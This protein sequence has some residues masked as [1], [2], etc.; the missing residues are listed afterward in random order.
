MGKSKT[1]KT[2]DTCGA[3]EFVEN[4]P[5]ENVKT[6]LPESIRKLENFRAEQE[7]RGNSNHGSD[8][9]FSVGPTNNMS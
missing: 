9:A 8:V 1:V 4:F 3:A 2:V 5:A 6:G 7:A